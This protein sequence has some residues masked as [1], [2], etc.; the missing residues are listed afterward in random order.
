MKLADAI[1]ATNEYAKRYQAAWLSL[2]DPGLFSPAP[3]TR[4]RAAA[5]SEVI[6]RVRLEEAARREERMAE[7]DER[8]SE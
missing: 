5:K 2:H 7:D 1:A 4:A 6:C 3:Q 8:R